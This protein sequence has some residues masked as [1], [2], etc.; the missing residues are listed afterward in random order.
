MQLLCP[1]PAVDPQAQ[2]QATLQIG[3]LNSFGDGRLIRFEVIYTSNSYADE[4]TE[5]SDLGF[6]GPVCLAPLG[7]Q[8]RTLCGRNKSMHACTKALTLI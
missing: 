7:Q 3:T 4:V 6:R 8:Q 5:V 2:L 1:C